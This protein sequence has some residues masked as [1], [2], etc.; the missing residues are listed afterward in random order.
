MKRLLIVVVLLIGS[1]ISAHAENWNAEM[2]HEFVYGDTV[3]DAVIYDDFLYLVVQDFGIEIVDLND[4]DLQVFTY[5][6][7]PGYSPGRLTLSENLLILT[8]RHNDSKGIKILDISV[9]T[10]P[11]ELSQFITDPSLQYINLF[12]DGDSLFIATNYENDEMTLSIVDISDPS[13]PD[14]VWNESIFGYFWDVVFHNNCFCLSGSFIFQRDWENCLLIMDIDTYQPFPPYGFLY[15]TGESWPRSVC[16]DENYLYLATDS[17]LI[18][19]EVEEN[20]LPEHVS[21]FDNYNEYHPESMCI[22]GDYIYIASAFFGLHVVNMSDPLDIFEAGNYNFLGTSEYINTINISASFNKV[23]TFG[24][25]DLTST[26]SIK[27]FDCSQTE[28]VVLPAPFSLLAPSNDSTHSATS[29]ELSWSESSEDVDEYLIWYANDEQ[30]TENLDSVFVTDTSVELTDLHNN[31]TY[32]WKVLARNETSHGRWTVEEWSFNIQT[33]S[34][35]DL[36]I[37]PTEF[38][39]TKAYP[40]P[41][42]PTLNVSI[43]MPETSNLTVTVHNIMGQSVATLADGK[44]Y[45]AGTHSFTF[46]GSDHSSG[47]YFI[48]AVVPGKFNQIQKVVLMK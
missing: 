26:I 23:C 18:T 21:T 3:I 11:V 17:G 20:S 6:F 5:E 34:V 7:E 35:D 38:A 32:W 43:S 47:V 45:S 48:R 13:N 36:E 46:N 22:S 24:V 37:I 41:F 39:L 25:E 16:C 8:Y 33:S 42:N 31:T 9:R 10:S 12:V 14:Q 29:I 15:D 28:N 2:L 44:N 27:I 30:F 40:N 4:P 1:G 19:L